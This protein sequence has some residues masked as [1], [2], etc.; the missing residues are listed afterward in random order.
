[1]GATTS[2]SSSSP[3]PSSNLDSSQKQASEI[4]PPGCPMHQKKMD[5]CPMHQEPNQKSESCSGPAHQE[6]AYEYVQCP[7]RATQ[8]DDIDPSNM[9]PPPNQTPAPDQPFTLSVVREESSIPRAFT[10]KK[11]VYPSSQMFWNAMLRKGWKWKDDDIE[12]VDMENIIKIHN[13]N[14]EKAWSEIL[15]WEALHAKECPCGPSL[16]RFGG[17]AKEYSPRAQIRSWMGYVLLLI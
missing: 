12:A 7:M 2:T 15:K 1:M 14:N 16:I 8:K 13:K 5:G 10:D 6:R 17:K 4:P 11:W 3:Q 9:M